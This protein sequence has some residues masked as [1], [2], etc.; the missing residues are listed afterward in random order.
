VTHNPL[1]AL[2]VGDRFVVLARGRLAA[3]RTRGQ[4]D[5]AELRELMSGKG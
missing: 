1:H 3:E 5:E 4:T 2:Q